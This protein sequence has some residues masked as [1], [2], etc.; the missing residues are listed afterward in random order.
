[1]VIFD[2]GYLTTTEEPLVHV[3]SLYAASLRV[4]THPGKREMPWNFVIHVTGW[5]M[6]LKIKKMVKIRDLPWKSLLKA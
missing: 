2:D 6:S 3:A 4:P 1:M 5:E